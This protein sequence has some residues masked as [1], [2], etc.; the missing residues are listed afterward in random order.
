MTGQCW[1]ESFSE[2]VIAKKDDTFE[3]ATMTQC[4]AR[5]EIT[6][7]LLGHLQA[8]RQVTTKAMMH[9]S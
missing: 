6:T 9:T 7:A 1:R 5:K 4:N 2:T 3:H 8:L